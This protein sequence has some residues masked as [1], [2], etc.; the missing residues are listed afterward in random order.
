MDMRITYTEFIKS[1]YIGS[2]TVSNSMVVTGGLG[3]SSIGNGTLLEWKWDVRL[4][5]NPRLFTPLI[6]MLGSRQEYEIWQ[7]L[8]AKL[9]KGA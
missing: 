7:G 2:H 1:E 5:G 4:R 6:A 3:S 8:K 9:E